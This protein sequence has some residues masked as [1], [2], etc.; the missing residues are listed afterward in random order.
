MALRHPYENWSAS[1]DRHP[2]RYDSTEL[3]LFEELLRQAV[4]EGE[5]G[6]ACPMRK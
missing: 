3:V 4:G 1:F 5:G 6:Q 2:R